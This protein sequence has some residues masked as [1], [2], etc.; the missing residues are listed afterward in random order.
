M[1]KDK[2]TRAGESNAVM[3]SSVPSILHDRYNVGNAVM[4]Q[5]VCHTT[6]VHIQEGTIS[7][8][9]ELCRRVAALRPLRGINRN[10]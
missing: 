10:A 4:H 8:H 5:R 3:R 2:D 9:S 6:H 1:R 7:I